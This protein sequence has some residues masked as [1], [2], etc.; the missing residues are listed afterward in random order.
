MLLLLFHLPGE[1]AKNLQR[2]L[3][4]QPADA[5][6]QQHSAKPQ[7]LAAAKA[8]A[9]AATFAASIDHVVAAPAFSPFHEELSRA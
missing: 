4:G 9:A 2:V 8:H 1:L 6:N 3:A 7:P 5:D